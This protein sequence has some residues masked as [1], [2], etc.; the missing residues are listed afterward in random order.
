[1]C[2]HVSGEVTSVYGLQ[3]MSNRMMMTNQTRMMLSLW[4][5]QGNQRSHQDYPR[6]L[7][8]GKVRM[9]LP[10]WRGRKG[11]H[12]WRYFIQFCFFFFQP[13]IDSWVYIWL[14]IVLF[15]IIFSWQELDVGGISSEQTLSS[16]SQHPVC[17]YLLPWGCWN[18]TCDVMQIEYE[19]ER[20]MPSIAFWS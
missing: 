16:S 1:M 17:K 11:D 12:M 2:L 6:Y 10:L 20:E 15:L 9:I 13:I 4:E 14:A 5:S 19:E 8:R 3:M 7:Q 18:D